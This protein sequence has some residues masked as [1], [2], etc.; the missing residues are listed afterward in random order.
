MFLDR[1][2]GRGRRPLALLASLALIVGSSVTLGANAA[3]AAATG[4]DAFTARLQAMYDNPEIEY[5]PDVRWWLA[6]GLNTD[7]TLRGNVEE[8]YDSGFGAAEFLAMPEPGADDAIYGWGSDEWT[9]DTRLVIEEATKR[10]MGFSL[11]SGTNWA[12]ANL[13]DTYSWAPEGETATT[14]DYDNKAASKELDYATIRLGPGEAFHGA[15]PLSPTRTASAEAK[16]YL[17]QAV[18]AYKVAEPRSVP[19]VPEDEGSGTGTLDL[20]SGQVL[21]GTPAVS[22]SGTSYTLNY[23][24]PSD[25]DYVVLAFWMHGT[26]QTAEPSVSKNYAINY[27]DSYG[28]DALKDYWDANVWTPELE[29]LIRSSG[30]GE[31]YMDSLELSSS[32]ASGALWGYHF[33]DEFQ[34]RRGYDLTPYLPFIGST[35]TMIIGAGARQ[36]DYNAATTADQATIDK[37][38]NDFYRTQTDMYQEKVLGPLQQWLHS[39][40]MTLRAE[41]SYGTAFEISTPAKYIDGIETESFAQSADVDLYRGILGSANMY[42]RTFSSETGAVSG[43]NY[44]YNMDYWTQLAYL[45]FAEG[46]SRTVFHGYPGIEGSSITRWPGHEGMFPIFSERFDSR[47][48]ASVSYPEWTTMLARYQKVLRQGQPQRDIAILRTDNS[49][50]AYGN[51][52]D[53]TPTEHNFSMYDQPYYWKDLSL[54]HNGYTYDYFSPLLLEDTSNV[55]WDATTL[56]PDG[57]AYQAIIVYQEQMEKSSAEALL[58]IAKDGLPV[59][60]VNNTKESDA[61]DPSSPSGMLEVQYKKAASVSKYLDDS[62]A[63]LKRVVNQIKALPN[64]RE[65]NNQNKTLSTL[66]RL[67]VSPRAAFATPN[68]K[69]LTQTRLD[70]AQDIFYA[71]AHSFKYE[72]AKNDPPT[73]FTM[74]FDRVGKPYSIDGWSGEIAPIGAYK[75]RGGKT[76]VTLTLGAGE[77]AMIALNLNDPGTAIHAVHTTADEAVLDGKT[78]SIKA[79]SSGKYTTILSDG[80]KVSTRVKVPAP[81]SLDRWNIRVQDWNAGEQVINTE[82]KFGHTT[83]EYYYTT[84]KTSLTFSNQTLQPWKDLPATRAQLARLS[85]KAGGPA[86]M[87]Q[88]SG[89]GTYTTTFALPRHWQANN[90]AQLELGSTNGGIAEVYING[91][92]APG[93]DLRTLTTDVT[94]LLRPGRNTIRI[95]V[96]ST[97]TNRMLERGYS[98]NPNDL[99]DPQAGGWGPKGGLIQKGTPTVQDYGLVGPTR[100][101]PYTT[102]AVRPKR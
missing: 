76:Y 28:I 49:F 27:I 18:V 91:Q 13:P 87:D 24:A 71:Y 47:Q 30:R 23:T 41:P 69:I 38:R 33:L 78:V 65:I 39:H 16:E 60:F 89:V 20:T 15:L 98:L 21:T 54:Q 11:T 12:V 67:G 6:E 9:A 19:D 58:R 36:F 57:P 75:I 1:F 88:V 37:V 95:V 64:V 101:V 97:L 70:E 59:V 90:G 93:V 46:V 99:L 34:T 72:V 68:D 29:N 77:N 94:A 10:G 51:P 79:T 43:A 84:K 52:D 42:G 86:S 63:A 25:G 17:L 32:G 3:K 4:D 61:H 66:R 31:I 8:I 44:Q 92:K 85:T 26:G 14:F 45:Q 56:Q 73:T 82:T 22:G 53:R 48:P 2:H 62:D 100:L 81:I 55:T 80:S 50:I 5:R 83:R 7:A 96:S 74:V 35:G 40:N 102:A